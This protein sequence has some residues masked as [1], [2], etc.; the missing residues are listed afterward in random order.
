MVNSISNLSH[1]LVI[2]TNLCGGPEEV[3]PASCS[4]GHDHPVPGDQGP[5]GHGKR[6]LPNLLPSP[7]E[8]GRQEGGSLLSS[9][10]LI[11]D[12]QS[13]WIPSNVFF[14]VLQTKVFLMAGRKRKKCKTSNYLI[15]TDPTNLSRD[16]NCY[17][18]KLRY[19]H[20]SNSWFHEEKRRQ[21]FSILSVLWLTFG[22]LNL[23]LFFFQVQRFGHKVHNLWWRWKPR[24]E[25][26]CQRVRII[27]TRAGSCLLR[28]SKMT[29]SDKETYS[30]KIT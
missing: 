18:G 5:Q 16:T 28:E 14:M 19:N 25:A 22:Q 30:V 23:F 10:T 15:S 6:H 11:S 9:H 21:T 8:G 24:Q 27:A 1:I 29:F 17:I 4:Q 13:I 3:C 7:G 12:L 2:I 20:T 26:V